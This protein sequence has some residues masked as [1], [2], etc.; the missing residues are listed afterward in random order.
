MTDLPG[1]A[2]DCCGDAAAYALGAL[3][4]DE[5]EAFRGHLEQ[6]AICRDELEALTGVVQ[7]LPMA[8]PQ[9]PAPRRLRRRVMRAIRRQPP[10]TTPQPSPTTQQRRGLGTR[11]GLPR[12]EG[13]A[14]LGAVGAACAVA[15]AVIAI[16]VGAGG[17]TA[18]R[19]R[20]IQA[21]VSGISGS[22]ELKISAQRGELVVRH[23]S[24]PP[25]GHVYEV[26][27]KAPGRAPRPASVLFTVNPQG[28]ADVSIP[29][30]LRG[31]AAVLVT[32]EPAGG[33]PVPTH[34]PVIV[35]Q[36]A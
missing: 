20:V 3:E 23:L 1:G 9:H 13:R 16:V 18:P 8:A 4:P 22:A 15:A 7:A 6:C 10:A 17:P 32:P 25:P 36:L 29:E 12:L 5:A 24:S 2:H 33:T 31:I 28:A 34:T 35:A 30:T 11:A 21:S 26:W 27:L 19:P 14:L